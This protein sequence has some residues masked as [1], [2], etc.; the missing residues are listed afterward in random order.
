MEPWQPFLLSWSLVSI[1]FPVISSPLFNCLAG[2]I[3]SSM[4]MTVLDLRNK[5]M[6]T[7]HV[8][9]GSAHLTECPF[10][11]AHVIISL[12]FHCA[13]TPHFLYSCLHWSI[14]L[15][16]LY[17]NHVNSV[18]T[19][20]GVHCFF[21]IMLSFHLNV[22][23]VVGLTFLVLVILQLVALLPTSV[24][25][26]PHTLHMTATKRMFILDELYKQFSFMLHVY[27][28]TRLG[29]LSQCMQLC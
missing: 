22:F 15:W 28:R 12:L 13:H 18:A 23:Q 8:V 9:P 11:G 17:L 21:D 26:S 1:F 14:P 7:C 24:T 4:M 16:I 3:L 2:T 5:N 27:L 25:H 10:Y 29:V 19:N 20:T 6:S